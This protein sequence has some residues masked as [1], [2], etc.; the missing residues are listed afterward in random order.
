MMLNKTFHILDHNSL[1]VHITDDEGWTALHYSARCGSYENVKFFADA[2]TDINLKTNDGMNC[3]HI[4]ADYGH[5]NLCKTLINRHSFDSRVDSN[6]GWTALHYSARNG[7][8]ELV[9]Y[10]ANIGNLIN[11]K[12]NSGW[13]CLH[14]AA[15]Y[16]HLTLCK[17]LINNHNFNVNIASNDG[18]TALH[19]SAR[20]GSYE[21]VSFFSDEGTDINLKTYDGRNCFHIAADYGHLTLCKTLI[22]KHNFNV[23]IA[24]NDGWTA[25]H[26]SA[27]NGSCEFV[28]F[29]CDVGTDINL[30]TYDGRNCFHI[31]ADYGH[32]TLGK[33]LINKHNFDLQL[34]DKDGWTAL[35][36]SA[37]NGTYELVK[38]FA[39]M[40]TDVNLKIN[41]GWNCLHIAA[42]YGH[43]NLCKKLINKHNFD[44]QI[45]NNDGWTGLHFSAR[46]GSYELVKFFAILGTDIN[47][48]TNLGWNCLHIAALHGN[49]TLCKK[50][51]N[52]HKFDIQMADEDGWT[53]LHYSARNGS[54]ELVKFFCDVGT[55]INLKTNDGRN[56]V[57]IA[58]DYGH[59][60][61]CKTLINKHNFDLQLAD[62]DGWTALHYSARNGTYELVKFFADMGTDVNLKINLGW[63]CLHIAALY[64]HLNLCKKLI[65]KHNFDAQIVNNDGWTGLHFSARSGSYELVKFFA[66]LGT[67]INLKT[68][69]GWNCLHIAALH[70]HLT[71]CKT[72]I[73]KHKFD[74]QIADKDGWT[75]LHYSARNGSYELV[76]FFCDVGTNINLKTNDGRNCVH[77]AADYG[78]LTLC[79]TL[80]N[81]HNFDLQ[82]ADKD[83]WTAL[84]YSARNGTYELVKFFADMGTD[85]NLKINLGW[86]C[87][88]IA[89]LYGHLNLCKKL[90]NKHNFDAQIVNNDGWTGLHFSARSGSYELVKFFAIL[91]T[92]I[93]LKTNLGWNCLHIAALH[94]HLTLCKTLI[95]KHKFDIQI[96]DKDGWTALHYSARNGSYELVK[97]F[98]D[99]GTDIKLKTNDGS[100]CLHI[101]ALYG[102]L[103]LCKLFIEKHKFDVRIETNYEWTALH[104]SAKNGSFDLFS[105]ILDKGGEI[106][107]KTNKMENVLHLSS[108]Y[109]HFDICEFVLKYFI[110]DYE[111]NNIKKQYSLNGKSYSSQVFYKYKIIFLHAMDVDGNTYLHL[112]AKGNQ[113]KVCE[114]LFRYDTEITTLL[115]KEDKTARKIAKDNGNKD[116]LNAL[117]VEYERAGMFFN[118][119]I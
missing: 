116:V 3:F 61:L 38:F 23:Q 62:K 20:H 19:Y 119:C 115:N 106:F 39:D 67:D 105:Y 52:K 24:N 78:H 31:A 118:N 95:N 59:L 49:L 111:C 73:N 18:W 13:N 46:S 109:G 45:V 48:K 83:G 100:N 98:V 81:K 10:F 103:N 80:I 82:L 12:T 117:K 84:H 5:L 15:F 30:K 69:L 112:A 89:A 79:K 74:I 34:A 7:S 16:G 58:A 114:L 108:L 85:V 28:N 65:N 21:L 60:A 75:A 93:N 87:L 33:T 1:D 29:L 51:I 63:N 47:L 66:V 14:I 96:A 97:F 54:Y 76:K 77:I 68:N 11:L 90:I 36:Y 71:L 113:A 25:L 64:R 4:A 27:K 50:L 22:N 37:R 56:C 86:N 42:L 88:H 70:G 44:A 43:L 26:Y 9:K 104:F 41:L 53:A 110:K 35:H 92:D 8:Y 57:H 102:H 107:C 32:L 55:N 2:G 72:L 40:G 17:T 6:D 101:A 99:M 94:G 91:G